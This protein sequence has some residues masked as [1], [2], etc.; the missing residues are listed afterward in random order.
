MHGEPDQIS[1]AHLTIF[2][3]K[4]QSTRNIVA[5]VTTLSRTGV[6]SQKFVRM[7][8]PAANINFSDFNEKDK[9]DI[10]QF[11]ENEQQKAKFQS[12]V[13]S[14]TDMCWTKCI[15][16]KISSAAIDKSE[17]SCL[18]NCVNRFI[19]AQKTVVGHLEHLGNRG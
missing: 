3:V 16:S 14:L 10:Q 8:S 6:N 12:N 15:Q 5:F 7:D 13:H 2:C 11:I 1:D 4:P 19:D 18:E 9:K 17:T